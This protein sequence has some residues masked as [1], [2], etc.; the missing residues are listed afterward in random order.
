MEPSPQPTHAG[1]SPPASR[2][3]LAYPNR[4]ESIRRGRAHLIRLRDVR[5]VRSC[6]HS[7]LV[8]CKSQ[9]NGDEGG[10]DRRGHW[11]FGREVGVVEVHGLDVRCTT[12]SVTSRPY[13]SLLA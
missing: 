1:G 12:P 5:E 8:C 3:G 13:W 6:H 2:A 9:F 4:R 11:A 7:P 10:F